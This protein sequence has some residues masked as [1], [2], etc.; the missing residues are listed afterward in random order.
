MYDTA[1]KDSAKN[2][3]GTL[4][5]D[6]EVDALVAIWGEDVQAKLDGATRNVK[7]FDSIAKRLQ[8]LGFKARTAVQCREKIKKLKG[9]YRKTKNHNGKSG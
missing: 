4:W 5:E 3:R 1:A 2:A 7:V 6:E 9:A 8:E